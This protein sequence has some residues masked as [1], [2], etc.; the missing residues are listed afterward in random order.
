MQTGQ[1]RRPSFCRGSWDVRWED[2]KIH[3]R[4]REVGGVLSCVQDPLFVSI[5]PSVSLTGN[6]AV[7]G[8]SS[9]KC[10]TATDLFQVHEAIYS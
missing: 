1:R 3:R 6:R 9:K 5:I 7:I 8:T 2:G 4:L 10:Y